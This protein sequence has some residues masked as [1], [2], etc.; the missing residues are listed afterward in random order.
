MIA[1]YPMNA[2][3]MDAK[4]T[5]RRVWD[6]EFRTTVNVFRS[7][8]ADQLGVKPHERSRSV[9]DLAWQCVIGERVIETIL[10]KTEHDLRNV[11]PV[12][13][14]PEAMEEIV[15]A[16]ES[17]HR[18]AVEKLNRLPEGEFGR[19]VTSILAFGEWKMPQPEALWANVMDQ[20]HHRGQLTIY[21]RQAG[22]KVPSIYGPSGDQ[23]VPAY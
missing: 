18:D 14:P 1:G 13:P 10:G 21:L 19:I 4:E 22:G 3:Q 7:F 11:P 5:F 2:A 16:Y 23:P 12:P 6:R 9:R 20:V 17:A 15:A 8:P